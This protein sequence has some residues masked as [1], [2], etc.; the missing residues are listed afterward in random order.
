MNTLSRISPPSIQCCD[1]C[2]TLLNNPEQIP[3]QLEIRATMQD[4][5]VCTLLRRQTCRDGRSEDKA[6]VRIVRRG[7]VLQE[8][9]TGARLLRLCCNTDLNQDPRF[10]LGL[11]IRP[12]AQGSVDFGLLRAW[13]SWCN[14]NHDCNT[15]QFEGDI[16]LPTR[17]LYVG[18]KDDPSTD[19]SVVRLVPGSQVNDRK[20]VALSHRWGK[21]E[22]EEKKMFCTSQDNINQRLRGFNLSSLPKTFQDAVNATRQLRIP[23]LWID[24]LC[25]I[26]S[27]DNGKDWI[28]ESR[29]MET[30]FSEAYCVLAATSATDCKTGFL[31]R[32]MTTESVHVHNAAGK[33]FYVS[34]DIDDFDTDVRDAELNKRAWVMQEGVLARRTIHFSAKH[35][36]FECGTG[37]YCENLIKLEF[38]FRRKYFT[39][40]PRF[41]SRLLNSGRERT[42]D[43]LYFLIKD[44]SERKLSYKTD[45]CVAMSGLQDRIAQAIP[46]EGRYGVFEKY[47]HRNLLW[48]ASDAKLEKIEYEGYVPSWSWMAYDGVIC[49][50]DE[51]EIPYGDIQLLTSLRFDQDCDCGHALVADVGKFQ[52]CTMQSDGNRYAVFDLSKTKR[53]WIRY[54]VED[55]KNLLEEHCVVVGSTLDTETYYI[56]VT[57]PTSVEGEY[58]RIGIG[59]VSKN[60]VVREQ[61]NV[62]VV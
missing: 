48:H 40:D 43:F 10:P 44:Y 11:P 21:L 36:Y 5:Q 20:Y 4:C 25:I 34:T 57:R 37:V 26:Q 9:V 45:K 31:K 35:T 42:M 28:S 51:K 50:L 8:S 16:P 60:C 2:S 47:L 58:E 38:P 62:R 23:Y 24:S 32:I 13:L 12:A 55:G 46:C 6:V 61:A 59:L 33:Q 15:H 27:G 41:P 19:S 3:Q 29:R 53:G 1:R 54:D 49:F 18:A 22:D 30:V 39:L 7:A 14:N 52:N 56:L 17:L